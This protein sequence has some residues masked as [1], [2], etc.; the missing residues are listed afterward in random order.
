MVV[1]I[2]IYLYGKQPL[3]DNKKSIY[4]NLLIKTNH[5][6]LFKYYEL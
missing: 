3:I 2:F 4:F 5:S 6:N 1:L